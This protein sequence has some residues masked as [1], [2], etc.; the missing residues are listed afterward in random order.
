VSNRGHNSIAVF[1]IGADH[2]LTAAGYVTGDIKTPC[3]FNIDT[4]GKWMLIASQQFPVS[5]I[6][7]KKHD[8]AGLPCGLGVRS[9]AR[10]WFVL[11]RHPL[12]LDRRDEC[13]RL[14]WWV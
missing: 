13:R 6:A 14:F 11:C 3:N 7:W 10:C 4:T 12:V 8:L 1:K 2:K 5:E 9:S